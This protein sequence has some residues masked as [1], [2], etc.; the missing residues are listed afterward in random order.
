MFNIHVTPLEGVFEY[1]HRLYKKQ[2][3]GSYQLIGNL[4]E[5]AAL[6]DKL[7]KST[8]EKAASTEEKTTAEK[9]PAPKGPSLFERAVAKFKS[10]GA[11]TKK[12]SIY[13]KKEPTAEDKDPGA[14]DP[15]K[16]EG[17]KEPHT[18]VES[19]EYDQ[20]L[21][22][23]S[24]KT[25]VEKPGT[26]FKIDERTIVSLREEIELFNK[27]NGTNIPLDQD[28]SQAAAAF[29][30]GRN[31]KYRAK[32]QP[33]P[34]P[35]PDSKDDAAVKGA[36]PA[37]SEYDEFL[38]LDTREGTQLKPNALLV[39]SK[40][41]AWLNKEIEFFN[42]RNG[43]NIPTD[44]SINSMAAQFILDS[45]AAYRAKN[46]PEPKKKA[47]RKKQRGGKK[48]QGG[49]LDIV[50][51]VTEILK[52]GGIIKAAKGRKISHNGKDL[53]GSKDFAEWLKTIDNNVTYSEQDEDFDDSDWNW[54]AIMDDIHKIL[55]SDTQDTNDDI[56][57]GNQ[58]GPNRQQYENQA[59]IDAAKKRE[60]SEFY[61]EFTDYI[62]QAMQSGNLSPRQQ[63]YLQYL[64]D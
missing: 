12:E 63:E 19:P 58:Y 5:E 48:Q 28:I 34:Q 9:T 53:Y 56:A 23:N 22:L 51:D 44:K 52:A 36:A 32:Y 45:N 49:I 6:R 37:G 20:F 27:R 42:A 31:D 1:K 3:D 15:K 41:K 39:N 54:K 64:Q 10:M 16:M 18:N 21:N 24:D 60:D 26:L 4:R 8:T 46:A 62:V 30:I 25:Y 43:T 50:V 2:P 55:G 13:K 40:G 29:I 59:G 14:P 47:S 11:K 33:N 7:S 57:Q 61:K 38:R 17:A 35:E